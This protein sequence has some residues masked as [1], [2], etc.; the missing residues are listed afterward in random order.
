[1]K[2]KLVALCAAILTGGGLI[3][4]ATSS[5]TNFNLVLGLKNQGHICSGN[6]YERLDP[7]IGENGVKE[8]WVCCGCHEIYYS[9]QSILE[10]NEDNWKDMNTYY[11]GAETSLDERGLGKLFEEA[12]TSSGGFSASKSDNTLTIN[13]TSNSGYYLSKDRFV[14][15]EFDVSFSE[16]SLTNP[17]GNGNYTNSLIV[18]GKDLGTHV[19]GYYIDVCSAFTA[20]YEIK[21]D[22]SRISWISDTLYASGPI[23]SFTVSLTNST[24]SF[25][26]GEVSRSLTLNNRDY[27]YSNGYGAIGF[28][29]T[30]CSNASITISNFKGKSAHR[31]VF[32]DGVQSNSGNDWTFNSDASSF[33]VNSQGYILSNDTYK[34]FDLSI[35]MDSYAKENIYNTHYAL[36]SIIVGGGFNESGYLTGFVIEF[37]QTFVE[38]AKLNGDSNNMS[39][40]DVSSFISRDTTTNTFEIEIRGDEIRY[41][42]GSANENWYTLS[43]YTGGFI[44]FLT[45][46]Y[47]NHVV[48]E[49]SNNVSLK[50]ID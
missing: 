4:C 40:G 38:I 23:T 3:V 19:A 12:G 10:Y 34:D 33:T 50:I 39:T 46:N 31:S 11:N 9:K 49:G 43:G 5:S 44:G 6:H 16:A 26:A 42:S 8:Y 22:G 13:G 28:Y 25:T 35:S 37:E 48:S 7:N 47:N 24:L 41:R 36:N 21:E 17:Y 14:S 18:C 45:N 30:N 15:F 32:T 20:I 29:N 1:M 2:K 27:F